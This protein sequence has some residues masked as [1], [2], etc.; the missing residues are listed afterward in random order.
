MTR[1]APFV[2]ILTA[3]TACGNGPLTPSK[4]VATTDTVERWQPLHH[5]VP[6]TFVGQEGGPIVYL[7][8]TQP[9]PYTRPDGTVGYEEDHYLQYA[10]CPV[11][12]I[13]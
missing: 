2:V 8:A 6:A 12:P 5:N 1:L 9:R 3:V 7:C 4:T 13:D 10:T 11:E